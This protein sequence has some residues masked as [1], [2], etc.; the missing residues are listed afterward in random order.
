[1]LAKLRAY[2]LQ[3]NGYDTVEANQRLGLRVDY[4]DYRLPVAILRQFGIDKVRLL[5]NNPDKV[6]ALECAGIEVFERVPCEVVPG[7]QNVDYLRVKK[8]KLHHM[9]TVA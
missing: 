7:P 4:R 5:T 6:R 2:E 1:M 9:L 3:D 8:Q